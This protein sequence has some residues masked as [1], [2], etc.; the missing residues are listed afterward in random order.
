MDRNAPFLVL[1]DYREN[2]VLDLI[3]GIP[4]GDIIAD[5]SPYGNNATKSNSPLRISGPGVPVLDFAAQGFLTV[6]NATE[7]NIGSGDMSYCFWTKSESFDTEAK[8]FSKNVRPII[9]PTSIVGKNQFYMYAFDNDEVDEFELYQITASSITANEWHFNV[10]VFDNSEL[11]V[12]LYQ[13]GNLIFTKNRSSAD[14]TYSIVS[15][16][17][18]GRSLNT[19]QFQ[20]QIAMVRMYKSVL[21]LGQIKKIYHYTRRNIMGLSPK[22]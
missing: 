7:L 15:D 6:P 16:I 5:N 9:G 3:P 17:I 20:G 14:L 21:T 22:P 12:K 10:I 1:P 19:N 4:S 2:L 13:D 8:L 18:I 11:P